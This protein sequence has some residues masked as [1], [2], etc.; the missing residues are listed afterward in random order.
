[1][2]AW[3]RLTQTAKGPQGWS[4]HGSVVVTVGLLVVPLAVAGGDVGNTL[5]TGI[6]CSILETIAGELEMA[7]IEFNVVKSSEEIKEVWVRLLLSETSIIDV[8]GISVDSWLIWSLIKDSTD[9]NDDEGSTYTVGLSEMMMDPVCRK[10][11][12]VETD[13]N[14]V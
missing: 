3:S 4:W 2:S 9:T 11:L 12:L 7:D 6:D 5:L 13:W 8:L 1:M 14:K 10:S